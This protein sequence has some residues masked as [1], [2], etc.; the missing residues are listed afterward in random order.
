MSARRIARTWRAGYRAGVEAACL[1]AGIDPA[2]VP[3]P[4]A[5]RGDQGDTPEPGDQIPA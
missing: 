4:P 5:I 1:V 2:K 3:P